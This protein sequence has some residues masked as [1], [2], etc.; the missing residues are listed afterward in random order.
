MSMRGGG[1]SVGG[2]GSGGGGGSIDVPSGRSSLSRGGGGSCSRRGGGGDQGRHHAPAIS[3]NKCEKA[4]TT[5]LFVVG[6]NCVFCEGTRALRDGRD[7]K[8]RTVFL[9]V[10]EAVFARCTA[11]DS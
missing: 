9:R 11:R 4:L 2:G 8:K 10:R 3:C 7:V 1:F 6:C 5:T